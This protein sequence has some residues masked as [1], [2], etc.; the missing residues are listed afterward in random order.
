MTTHLHL[1]RHAHSSWAEPGQRD[2][3]RPLDERGRREATRLAGELAARPRAVDRVVC[4]TATRAVETFDLIRPALPNGFTVE[5]S[6]ALYAEGVDAYFSALRSA[7]GSVLLV[8][9]NPTLEE[10][11]DSLAPTVESSLQDGIGTAN[12]L[13]LHHEPVGDDE[14]AW[15][16]SE[17]W[18]P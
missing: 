16:L 17:I 2:H 1:L 10:L 18:R 13:T 4:S 8:G 15:R 5:W 11:V 14:G 3:Q 12:W 6:D 7:P 9:H